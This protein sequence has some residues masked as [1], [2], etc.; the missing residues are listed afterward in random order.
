MTT[1][2]KGVRCHPAFKVTSLPQLLGMLVSDM[3][4]LRQRE[5]WFIT[6]H[7]N[8]A[9][10]IICVLLS[11]GRFEEVRC[12]LHTSW[13]VFQERN[14]KFMDQDVLQATGDMPVLCSGKR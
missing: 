3:R 14:P 2:M 5:E 1:K 4:A 12:H 6:H 9:N 8:R 13:V 11:Q 10:V 7:G